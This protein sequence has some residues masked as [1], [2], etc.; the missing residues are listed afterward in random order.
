MA[1]KRTWLFALLILALI[2][3][4]AMAHEGG[5][6]FLGTVQACDQNT[7]TVATTQNGILAF[8]ITKTTKFLKSGEPAQIKDLNKGEHV[9]VHAKPSGESWEAQEVRF[10]TTK[11]N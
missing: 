5:K 2:G 11:K 9:V 10:G 3:T 6:H 4:A 8:T 7:L 1:S